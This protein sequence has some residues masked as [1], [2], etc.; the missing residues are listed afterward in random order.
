[1]ELSLSKCEGCKARSFSFQHIARVLR[2]ELTLGLV[3][4]TVLI[5]RSDAAQSASSDFQLDVV[6]TYE[7]D[8]GWMTNWVWTV[9]ANEFWIVPIPHWNLTI[10]R[11][12]R[13]LEVHNT[14]GTSVIIL[15]HTVLT[16]VPTVEDLRGAVTERHPGFQVIGE[17]NLNSGCG[18]ATVFDLLMAEEGEPKRPAMAAWRT[19]LIVNEGSLL[20]CTLRTSLRSQEDLLSTFGRF[21]LGVRHPPPEKGGQPPKDR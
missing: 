7:F 4:S 11:T 10:N 6:P 1:M 21:L 15:S 18:A 9:G 17:Q 2:R 8:A 14:N 19:A 3:L 5:P 20:E 12:G 16:N 13:R